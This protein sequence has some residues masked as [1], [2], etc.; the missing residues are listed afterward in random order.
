MKKFII[1]FAALAIIS[2]C[3]YNA[4]NAAVFDDKGKITAEASETKYVSPDTATI[5]FSVET[6]DKNSQKAVDLN[7]QKMATIVEAVKK[8]LAQNESVKTSSYNLHPRYEYNNITKKDVLTGYSVTNSITVTLKD[9]KKTAKIIDIAT[10]SGATSVSGLS[11]TIQNTDNVCREL[12]TKATQKAKK[13]AET[14]LAA[15][16]KTIDT[17]VSVSYN[18]NNQFHHSPRMYMAMDSAM[19]AKSAAGATIEEGENKV[20]AYVTIVFTIK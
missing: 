13:E 6:S 3:V 2:L 19:N 12:T 17:V 10:Q 1:S 18:C 4:S 9:T 20:T 8:Q 15:L 5:S 11:F 14:V 16:G 7:N